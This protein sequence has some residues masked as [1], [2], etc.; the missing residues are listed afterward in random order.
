[1]DPSLKVCS[2]VP[3]LLNLFALCP[4][5]FQGVSSNCVEACLFPVPSQS[6]NRD[7]GI[8]LQG[9]SVIKSSSSNSLLSFSDSQ[10]ICVI[11]LLSYWT[12]TSPEYQLLIT[13]MVSFV[14]ALPTVK[15]IQDNYQ[16]SLRAMLSCLAVL[17]NRYLCVITTY[18]LSYES[19]LGLS[20]K[21]KHQC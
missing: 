1:M 7:A 3:I 6:H 20:Q 5:L 10:R 13:A 19:K 18:C 11:K 14:Q 4:L 2:Q 8:S 17:L 16:S 15:P 9:P 21:A 12:R